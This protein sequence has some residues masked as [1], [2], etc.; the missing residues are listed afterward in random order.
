MLHTQYRFHGHGSLRY[1]NA[2]AKPLRTGIFTIKALV[3]PYRKHSRVAVVVSKK[4]LKS[5]VGRNKMRRRV[6]DILRR[7]MP[8]FTDTYDVVVIVKRNDVRVMDFD[9][10]EQSLHVALKQ[11]GCIK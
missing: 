4:V 8:S 6:Y 2:N 5:A 3:N 1:V 9:A 11:I 10:L 7:A